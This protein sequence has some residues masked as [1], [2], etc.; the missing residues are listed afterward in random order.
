MQI[1]PLLVLSKK[2]KIKVILSI[3]LMQKF[4]FKCLD[5][6]FGLKNRISILFKSI[7]LYIRSLIKKLNSKVI[8]YSIY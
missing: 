4:E 5:L 1:W 8:F 6:R 3:K 2:H 7:N